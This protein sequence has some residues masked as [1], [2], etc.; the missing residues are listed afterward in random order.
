VLKLRIKRILPLVLS[1][2]FILA[3]SSCNKASDISTIET[4]VTTI[5]ITEFKTIPPPE[6][7]WTLELLNDVT[8]INGK[9][10]DLPFSLNDIGWTT[11]LYYSEYFEVA[12]S[13][14]QVLTPPDE[15]AEDKL[16]P[17]MVCVCAYAYED[18]TFDY[19]SSIYYLSIDAPIENKY[20]EAG[21]FLIINGIHIG[22]SREKVYKN[23]GF[24]N[25]DHPDV[26]S[27]G[28]NGNKLSLHFSSDDVLKNIVIITR[29]E[30]EK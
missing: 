24:P 16:G 15:N 11:P 10:I 22:D 23:L 21:E 14:Y 12:N 17:L 6:D 3:L 4:T 27:I 28:I 5:P 2:I 26:Y 7:G 20:V 19:N 30:E 18:K 29:P 8:Y 9:D 25:A 1:L 13:Y